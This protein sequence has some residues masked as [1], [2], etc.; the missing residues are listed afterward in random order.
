MDNTMTPQE[1][2]ELVGLSIKA[3]DEIAMRR[4]ALDEELADLEA[5][6]EM[7]RREITAYLVAS[8]QSGIKT[9]S[10]TASLTTSK[11]V[12][13]RDRAAFAEFVRKTGEVDLLEMRPAKT[14]VMQFIDAN[15]NTPEGLDIAT[16]YVVRLTAPKGN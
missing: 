4:R 15:G 12:Y 2:N 11:K 1:F 9:V 10:G 13:I 14:N 8:G 7:S 6:Y 3:R 5:M 16:E